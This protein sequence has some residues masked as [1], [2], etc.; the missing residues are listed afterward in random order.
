MNSLV[1]RWLSSSMPAG[2]Y[3]GARH[4]LLVPLVGARSRF[5][6]PAGTLP[7]AL[8]VPFSL[9]RIRS[10]H[11]GS[12]RLAESRPPFRMLLSVDERVRF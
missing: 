8:A 12:R 1:R 5:G 2:R 7:L 10:D 4:G 11:H 6:I 9:P 3:H